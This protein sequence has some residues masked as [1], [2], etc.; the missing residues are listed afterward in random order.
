MKFQWEVI[1]DKFNAGST[2]RAKVYGGWIVRVFDTDDCNT[3]IV[4]ESMV[5]VP[6]PEHKWKIS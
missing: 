3:E 4:S 2:Y 1:E 6:D 5:F